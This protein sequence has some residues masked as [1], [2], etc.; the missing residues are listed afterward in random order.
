MHQYL[1]D[2]IDPV[3]IQVDFNRAQYERGVPR[4]LAERRW[5]PAVAK[6]ARAFER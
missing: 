4:R 3:G 2:W 6:L 1:T 5:Q